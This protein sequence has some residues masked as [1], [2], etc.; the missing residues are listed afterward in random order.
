M[1]FLAI[2]VISLGFSGTAHAD[3][4]R[5]RNDTFRDL[6]YIFGSKVKDDKKDKTTIYFRDGDRRRVFGTK[7][8]FENDDVIVY[9]GYD[10]KG[11]KYTITKRK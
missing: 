5:D 8:L 10:S 6:G 4:D 2:A 7:K 1:L 11:K 9:R 3:D